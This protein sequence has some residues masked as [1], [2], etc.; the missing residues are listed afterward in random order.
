MDLY[1][2]K[3]S[4]TALE[5]HVKRLEITQLLTPVIY[6][7]SF[8]IYYFDKRGRHRRQML[9]REESNWRTTTPSAVAPTTTAR[10]APATPLTPMPPRTPTG[11]QETTTTAATAETVL[12][13]RVSG[14]R[15]VPRRPWR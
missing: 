10:A 3:E 1:D 9:F 6:T 2:V 4:L 8:M 15:G 13:A 11:Q 12:A 14:R 5:P 7:V